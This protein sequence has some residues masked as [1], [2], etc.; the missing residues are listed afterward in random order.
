MFHTNHLFCFS[1]PCFRNSKSQTSHSSVF[2]SNNV[3]VSTAGDTFWFV[4]KSQML[5][6]LP[7]DNCMLLFPPLAPPLLASSPTSTSRHSYIFPAVCWGQGAVSWRLDVK[8]PISELL[9]LP[10]FSSA[11]DITGLKI[12]CI[13]SHF[14]LSNFC[15]DH[16][17]QTGI[18]VSASFGFN[19]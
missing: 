2:L 11:A 19:S 18:F 8:H 9:F 7:H 1:S 6:L 14:H 5:S 4:H 3:T 12:P 13:A 10:S 17:R 15:L 16:F